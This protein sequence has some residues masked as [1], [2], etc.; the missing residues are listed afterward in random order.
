MVIPRGRR[1]GRQP[2]FIGLIDCR[3]E[4]RKIRQH[5]VVENLRQKDYSIDIDTAFRLQQID[6]RGGA[7]GSIT[8]AE[9]VFR[10]I[11][12]AP[13][14][15]ELGNEIREGMSVRI[16]AEERL[17]LILAGD[18]AESGTRGVDEHQIARVEQTVLVIYQ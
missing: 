16:D 18:A 2:E 1:V 17:V 7:G 10:R 5:V 12:T 9:N 13:L 3:I 4:F 11:P 6:Q 14:R 8:L 15:Q